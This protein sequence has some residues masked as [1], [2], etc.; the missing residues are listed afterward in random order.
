MVFVSVITPTYNRHRCIPFLIE[1]FQKQKYDPDLLELIILDDTSNPYPFKIPDLRVRYVHEKRKCLLWEK[2]NKLNSLAKGDIIVCMDDD[3]V[4]PEDRIEHAVETLVNNPKIDIVG[5]SSLHIYNTKLHNMF[6]FKALHNK[7][8]LNST[9]AYRRTLLDK[10]K[11]YSTRNNECFEE[12]TFTDNFRLN[13]KLLD[14]EKTIVCI[15]HD[16]NTVNKDIFCLKKNTCSSSVMRYQDY[17]LVYNIIPVIYW[18]NLTSSTDRKAWMEEQFKKSKF[19]NHTRIEALAEPPDEMEYDT[20]RFSKQQICCLLSHM[21][22]METSLEDSYRD[23]SIICEDDIDFKKL[24]NFNEIIHY[25]MASAPSKWDV[26]QLYVIN[27]KRSKLN[28]SDGLKSWLNWEKWKRTNFS[29]M[30]YII[31]K[32]YIKVLLEQLK[33]IT[34]KTNRLVADDYIYNHGKSYSICMPYFAEKIQFD[35]V[36]DKTHYQLH[37][38]NLNTIQLNY[39]IV[40]DIYPF[41][42]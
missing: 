24:A 28:K 2:R 5:C 26:L 33:K 10:T 11:Y 16:K 13:I 40:K 23:Y 22:A 37:Q 38:D 25:Y 32:D 35:S 39:E 34:K 31:K 41:E 15:A 17:K 36:I 18:I 9:F 19:S 8:I 27:M 6:L 20:K 12:R 29:T 14:N 30:I 7:T 21:K 1:Q 4:Y 3:D 42:N